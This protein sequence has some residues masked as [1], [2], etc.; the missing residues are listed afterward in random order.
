MY[1]AVQEV[2]NILTPN[3]NQWDQFTVQNWIR[4]LHKVGNTVEA[5][6]SFKTEPDSKAEEL[7]I[8]N[9]FVKDFYVCY[10]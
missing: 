8:A 4:K 5:V 9:R 1:F 6:L 3:F 2:L 7:K 10:G